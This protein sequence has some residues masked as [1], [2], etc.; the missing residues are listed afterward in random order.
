MQNLIVRYIYL[1][2]TSLLSVG[3]ILGFEKRNETKRKKQKK[4]INET[5]RI[6]KKIRNE[7]KRNE[8]NQNKP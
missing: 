6:E 3:D 1:K 4:F 5:K 7:A 8:T 2:L